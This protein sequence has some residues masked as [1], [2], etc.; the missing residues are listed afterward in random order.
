MLQ[1]CRWEKELVEYSRHLEEVAL[2]GRAGI[3]CGRVEHFRSVF[4]RYRVFLAWRVRG[5]SLAFLLA[6]DPAP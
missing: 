5:L 3:R 4:V 6:A 2:V 1:A